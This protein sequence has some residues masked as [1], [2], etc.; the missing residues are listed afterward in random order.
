[1]TL[2]IVQ[3]LDL[4]V[5]IFSLIGF[6]SWF[7]VIGLVVGIGLL[8]SKTSKILIA[9]FGGFLIGIFFLPAFPTI[10]EYPAA[11]P[12]DGRKTSN[13]PV[14][15]HIILD[16]F[17][18][19]EILDEKIDTQKKLKESVKNLFIGNGFRLFGRAHSEY[20]DTNDS[21]T[22][23]LNSYRGLHPDEQYEY[24]KINNIYTVTENK[25]FRYLNAIGY[26][27]R[28][29]QISF[30]NFC[31]Q[32]KDIIRYC[33]TYPAG[34]ASS[35][36]LS[37]LKE[38]EKIDLITSK[39]EILYSKTLL[40]RIYTHIAGFTA[41]YG[42]A[43]PA[44]KLPLISDLGPIPVLPVF[45]QLISDVASGG[46]G[47]V[48]FAHLLLPHQPYSVDRNCDIRRPVAQWKKSEIPGLVGGRGNTA[49]SRSERYDDYV[50]QAQCALKKIGEL[51]EAMKPAGTFENATIIIHSDHGSR[52]AQL[53]SRR[54]NESRL[55]HQDYY[56]GFSSLFAVK[57]AHITPGYDLRML[58][59]ERLLR[60]AAGGVL[61]TPPVTDG[62]FVYLREPAPDSTFIKVRMPSIPIASSDSR[63][64]N[65]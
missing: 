35:Q 43:M 61:T 58:P 59:I 8:H 39:F 19:I 34:N 36:A 17:T 33:L 1:L 13:L 44:W 46:T 57:A 28:V 16:E 52:I 47:K 32:S 2:I 48:Y 6:G 7:I 26:D 24:D 41:R 5:D 31:E 9:V 21:L 3:Y 29:Y 10:E 30:L 38:V 20:A 64:G 56:D 62:N 23:A 18:G 54:L 22:S 49:N 40:P 51:I 53:R 11:P 37:Q 63:G 45:D 55:Q 27:I 50:D 12:T 60:H 15:V 65:E 4:R 14:Y 42:I 25:Y